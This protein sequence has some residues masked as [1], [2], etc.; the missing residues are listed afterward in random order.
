M[1][2]I[3]I[4][5]WNPVINRN[6]KIIWQHPFLLFWRHNMRE[7]WLLSKITIKKKPNVLA[8]GTN[9]CVKAKFTDFCYH[10]ITVIDLT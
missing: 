7:C 8:V 9:N 4:N 10:H 5:Y 1:Q 2:L 3:A 6:K